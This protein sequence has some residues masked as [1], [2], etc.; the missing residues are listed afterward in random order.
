MNSRLNYVFND[1]TSL[2]KVSLCSDEDNS[3]F[4]IS[5]TS[6]NVAL[7]KI[8]FKHLQAQRAIVTI[9]NVSNIP[10]NKKIKQERNKTLGTK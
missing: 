4:S 5:N 9:S 2:K 10:K 7:S 6:S 8:T 3:N 1:H